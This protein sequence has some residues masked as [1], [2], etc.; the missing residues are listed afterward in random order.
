MMSAIR[1]RGRASLLLVLAGAIVAAGCS[2]GPKL[3]MVRGTVYLNGKPVQ[4]GETVTGYVVFHADPAK[5][6]TTMEDVKANIEAD[7]SYRLYTRDKEGAPLG[8]YFVTVELARTSPQDP[9]DY[10]AIISERYLDKTKSNLAFEVVAKPEPGRYDVKLEGKDP[11][12]K[13]K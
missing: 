5:G 4:A 1:S 8:W 7:G 2:Q 9:Y 10:K 11:P 6:N 13:G 3:V 12:A